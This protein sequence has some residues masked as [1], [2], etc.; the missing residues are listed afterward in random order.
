MARGWAAIRVCVIVFWKIGG[1]VVDS[2]LS[3]N[4]RVTCI[5]LR[6]HMRC[7]TVG[8][9]HEANGGHQCYDADDD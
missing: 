2:S 8:N 9:H 5:Y 3:H 6:E 1:A 4:G 7:D